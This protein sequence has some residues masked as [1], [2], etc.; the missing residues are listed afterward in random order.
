MLKSSARIDLTHVPY[1]GQAP[2]LND[3]LGGQ[4]DLM[5][6]NLPELLPQIRASSSRLRRGA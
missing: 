4:I 2:A 5:F 3:L 1:K 6:G